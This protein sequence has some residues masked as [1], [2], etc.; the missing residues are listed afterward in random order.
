MTF[1]RIEGAS[2]KTQVFLYYASVGHPTFD[3]P[4]FEHDD[5]DA[6]KKQAVDEVVGVYGAE[7]VFDK[8]GNV[9]DRYAEKVEG[10]MRIIASGRAFDARKEL[11][12]EDYLWA[13]KKIRKTDRGRY[14]AYQVG[15][16]KKGEYWAPKFI[17]KYGMPI[18]SKY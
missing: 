17:E 13:V 15:L 9:Q 3:F 5:M 6:I 12:D 10:Q 14:E 16:T 7:S 4:A 18:M 2:L 8:D 1:K 11:V